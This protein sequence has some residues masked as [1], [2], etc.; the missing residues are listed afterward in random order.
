MITSLARGSD[1]KKLRYAEIITEAPIGN[2][3]THGDFTKPGSF[4][5]DDLSLTTPK[6]QAKIRRVLAKAPILIDLH[7]VNMPHAFDASDL[8]YHIKY[9]AQQQ[10][11]YMTPEQ[12][13]ER[14]Y[15][16][17][18]PR[19]D[20]L[21][22]VYLQN[23]GDDR[24]PMTPWIIAHRLGHLFYHTNQL[25]VD[26]LMK[27][28]LSTLEKSADKYNVEGKRWHN[29]S[30]PDLA[31][32]FGTTRACREG[33][34]VQGRI[35]EWFY[36]CFAQMC[37]MDDIKFN[38]APETIGKFL[39]NDPRGVDREFANLHENL[40]IGFDNLL[41]GAVGKIMVF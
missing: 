34:M 9:N 28:F 27:Q 23:E 22:L 21:N 7:F 29:P 24:V 3:E 26:R 12:L 2:I 25:M 20:A 38:K 31:K 33:L 16:D 4:Q 35:M 37:V 18:V 10:M 8:Q 19:P 36:D 17:I 14:W 13:A 40:L 30:W 6:R 15:V 39:G 11:G 32:V 1:F 41:N 5:Q